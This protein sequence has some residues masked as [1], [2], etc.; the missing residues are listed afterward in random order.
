MPN[1]STTYQ[2]L[3]GLQNSTGEIVYSRAIHDCRDTTDKSAYVDGGN[4]VFSS[5]W[6]LNGE[7][8]VPI[9]IELAVSPAELF[10]DWNKNINFYGIIPNYLNPP[11]EFIRIVPNKEYE[12]RTTFEYSK[13]YLIWGTYGK[14]G[15]G[16]Y[17]RKMLTELETDH[18]KS[19]LITEKSHISLKCYNIISAILKDREITAN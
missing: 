13:K 3:A 14:D 15:K 16:P 18:L 1:S 12:N 7:K 8:L 4:E 17:K 19:I 5:G 2:Y 6:N 11:P 9:V 10:N